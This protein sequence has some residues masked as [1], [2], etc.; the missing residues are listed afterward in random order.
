MAKGRPAACHAIC[1][2]TT[3]AKTKDPIMTIT[4]LAISFLRFPAFS[5]AFLRTNGGS[6]GSVGL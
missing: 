4:L 3:D 5:A 1:E 2:K 6:G